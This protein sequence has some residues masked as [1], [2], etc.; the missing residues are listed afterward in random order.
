MDCFASECSDLDFEKA[1][2]LFYVELLAVQ[3]PLGEQFE[4]VLCDNFYDLLVY[5]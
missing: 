3:K 1:V 5:T 2:T 4:K